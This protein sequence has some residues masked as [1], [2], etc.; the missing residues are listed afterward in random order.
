MNAVQRK[1]FGRQLRAARARKRLKQ[2]ELAAI[3]GVKPET[4]S[5]WETGFFEPDVKARIQ[6][7][8]VFGPI[9]KVF[10]IDPATWK[11]R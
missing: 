7:D 8:Q 9:E 10:K 6:L 3:V 11:G 2:T 1:R 4:V 5:R